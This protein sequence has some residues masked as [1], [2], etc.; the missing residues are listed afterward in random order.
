MTVAAFRPRPWAAIARAASWTTPF[1]VSRRL[2]EREVEARERE[3]DPEDVRLE[4]AERRLE[5]L[6]SGL[7]ALE[8][9]DRPRCP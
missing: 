8:N 2:L 7:V 4:D 5:Q 3:L 1:A 9:D 6:L